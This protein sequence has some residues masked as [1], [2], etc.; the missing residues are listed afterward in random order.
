MP[1]LT[2]GFV[3]TQWLDMLGPINLCM[4][5]THKPLHG[6]NLHTTPKNPIPRLCLPNMGSEALISWNINSVYFI[7]CKILRSSIHGILISLPPLYKHQA[8]SYLRYAKI[9]LGLVSLSYLRFFHHW[10]NLQRVFGRHPIG[11]LCRFFRYPINACLDDQLID[12][13]CASSGLK[14]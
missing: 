9:H 1:S 10:L 14:D 8:S 2:D 11:A 4:F 13:F 12:H 6:N 5:S 7:Q 3:W